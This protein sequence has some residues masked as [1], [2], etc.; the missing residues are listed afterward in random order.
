MDIC[1]IGHITLDR[2]VTP[3]HEVYMPG[4]AAYYYA[5]GISALLNENEDESKNMVSSGSPAGLPHP[6]FRLITSLAESEMDSVR[7]LQAKGIDTTVIK[8]RNT[9]FFENIYGDNPDERTQKVRA[10]ADPF[11]VEALEAINAKAD[12]SARYIV[13]GSLL[14]DDFSLDVF[15]YLHSKGTLVVD[16]Q[17]FLRKVVNGDVFPCD[18]ADKHEALK[19]VDI[20]KVNEHE[21]EV[22]T[23]EK[24]LRK[25]AAILA[26]WGV[27][28][29]LLSV[30]SQGSIILADGIYYEIP[31][32]PPK[33]IVDTTGCGDTYVMSY[34]FKR[35]QGAD[36]ISA[37]RFA[38]AVCTLKIAHSGPFNS[39]YAKAAELA[40]APS[41]QG[42]CP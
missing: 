22:I 41:R 19:Y 36:I 33:Q 29:V 9:V 38:A 40:T 42:S 11:T 7:E 1:C 2:I 8:S 6:T 28:E 13:L 21:A 12:I 17:G 27:R 10:K 5:H 20:L 3:G 16:A 26:S 34:L 23:G 24:D 14:A 32:F 37:G 18:W 39:T 4:G 30:G 25:A 35:S 15:R 31:A